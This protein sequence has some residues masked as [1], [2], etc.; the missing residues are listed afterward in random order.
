MEIT[1]AE[2]TALGLIL[3]ELELRGFGWRIVNA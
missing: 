2:R 3:S 1:D